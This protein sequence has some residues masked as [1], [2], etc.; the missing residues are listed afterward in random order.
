MGK[1]V[2]LAAKAFVDWLDKTEIEISERAT[3]YG[4][5]PNI[6]EG[7]STLESSCSV[8]VATAFGEY[9]KGRAI[10]LADDGSIKNRTECVAFPKE[11]METWSSDEVTNLFDSRH[12]L[13]L[14]RDIKNSARNALIK[15]KYSDEVTKAEVIATL[16][17]IHPPKPSNWQ[18]LINLWHYLSPEIIS[19]YFTRHEGINIFPALGNRS[20]F[21]ADEIVRVSEKSILKSEDD[22]KFLSHWL[23]ILDHSWLRYLDDDPRVKVESKKMATKMLGDLGLNSNSGGDELIALSSK[24]FFDVKTPSLEE[25]VGLTQI[26]AQLNAKVRYRFQI[27]YA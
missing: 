16:E 15:N 26:A 4:L 25:T 20:L 18:L 14:S 7:D 23:L 9:I 1:L 27:L 2:H 19:A 3:S 10:L 6:D 17:T 12:R 21:H 5:L 11:I 13:A 22:W 24:K 8:V